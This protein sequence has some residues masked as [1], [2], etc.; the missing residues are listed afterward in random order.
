VTISP[1]AKHAYV[2]ARDGDAISLVDRASDGT[3]T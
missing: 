2:T 3:L 1:D